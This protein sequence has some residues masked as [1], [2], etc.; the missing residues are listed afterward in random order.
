M[1]SSVSKAHGCP[2]PWEH[3]GRHAEDLVGLRPG[4]AG[5]EQHSELL[6]SIGS[7]SSA[8]GARSSD[9]PADTMP[10][11]TSVFEAIAP[12]RVARAARPIED[13]RAKVVI[14]LSDPL[15]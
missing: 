6:P 9:S 3:R 4:K 14:H 13:A 15:L 11:P 10:P 1:A 7:M 5:R 2:A 8:D 12:L